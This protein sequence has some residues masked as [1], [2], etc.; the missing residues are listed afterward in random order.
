M[1][2]SVAA[3]LLLT[4]CGGDT[5]DPGTDPTTPAGD[6]GDNGDNGD[7]DDR[8]DWPD[9]IIL[10][11]VPS[12]DMDELVETAQP[13][14]DLIAAELGIEVESFV[15]QSYTALVEAMSTGQ[16]D[17]GAFGPIALAQAMERAGAV[18]IL[19]S[20]R[21]GV[22][23]YHTQWFTND[24]DRFCLDDPVEAENPEGNILTYCNG[25]DAAQFGP[26]GEDALANIEAGETIYFVDAASASGYFYPATQLQQLG[27][28]PFTDIDAQFAGGHPNA[29][30]A[31]A[32]GEAAVGVSFDDARNNL[33]DED[34]EIG[35]KAIVF[36]WSTEIPNDGVVVSSDLPQSLQDAI[37]AAFEAVMA[38]EEGAA[39]FLAVY[40]IEGFQ[41]ADL[42]AIA[43]ARRVAE[44]FGD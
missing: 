17:I 37:K 38:T 20:I 5:T 33:F 31:V 30:Q 25:T 9:K 40:S 24:P 1:A 15:P 42:D 39:A 8:S 32:R 44:D 16:A 19:Q 26:V 27:I 35:Q 4:A 7:M 28:D 29:V 34:P 43:E 6:N 11:L 14:A 22:A 3:A 2:A 41:D 13:L 23:T 12:Q 10:G 21:R 18:P 36:A